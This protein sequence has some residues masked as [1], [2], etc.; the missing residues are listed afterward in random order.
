MWCPRLDSTQKNLRQFTRRTFRCDPHK[1]MYKDLCRLEGFQ[2]FTWWFFLFLLLRRIFV[3]LAE[4]CS[5]CSL[6][7][8]ISLFT[9][10]F[11]FF[12]SLQRDWKLRERKMLFFF[13]VLLLATAMGFRKTMLPNEMFRYLSTYSLRGASSHFFFFY[14]KN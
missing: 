8:K 6:T 11:F 2:L 1:E 5:T 10:F 3:A 13:W 7:T 4:I 12:L 9:R 14:I